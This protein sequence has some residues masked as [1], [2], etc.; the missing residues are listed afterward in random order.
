MMANINGSNRI[1][2]SQPLLLVL[3]N[4]GLTREDAYRLV[5]KQAMRAHEESIDFQAAIM[6]DESIMKHVTHEQIKDVFS[7]DRY[8]KNIDKIYQKIYK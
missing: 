3:V 6:S 2:F 5:Q 7:F 8:T 1:F 4:A